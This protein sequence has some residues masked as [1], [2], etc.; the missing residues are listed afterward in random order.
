MAFYRSIP[1]PSPF[2]PRSITVEKKLDVLLGG[3]KKRAA[4]LAN[5]IQ[6]K[7]TLLQEKSIELN[8]FKGLQGHEAV[9]LPQRLSEMTAL[10][11]E[12]QEREASLQATYAELSRMRQTLREQLAAKAS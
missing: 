10:V 8:C 4:A 7:Q 2:H 9:A 3:Y 1:A 6:E 12:Q 11:T 5:E